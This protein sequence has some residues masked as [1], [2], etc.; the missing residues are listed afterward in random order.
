MRLVLFWVTHGQGNQ[1]PSAELFIF[2]ILPE[3]IAGYW[4]PS[5][6]H[7]DGFIALN[8]LDHNCH[9][10]C[11]MLFVREDIPS[12]LLIIEEKPVETFCVELNLRNSKWLV[13]CSYNPHKNSL[14]NHLERIVHLQIS[15]PLI[16][17]KYFWEIVMLQVMNITY[18]LFAKTMA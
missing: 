13:N 7:T 5:E 17:R 2:L 16:I 18:N 4:N 1:K 15:Y 8:K 12:H 10:G 11:L 3:N 6:T 14:D 9:G